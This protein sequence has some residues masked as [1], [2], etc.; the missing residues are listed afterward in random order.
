ML[1]SDYFVRY[2]EGVDSFIFSAGAD[3]WQALLRL[4]GSLVDTPLDALNDKLEDYLEAAFNLGEVSGLVA[5]LK[6]IYDLGLAKDYLERPK[7]LTR[8]QKSA[9]ELFWLVERLDRT[10][11]R[12][13]ESLAQKTARLSYSFYR[14]FEKALKAA[15]AGLPK[16]S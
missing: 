11:I 12:R 5:A 16:G 14:L 8:L 9:F 6:L 10:K 4:R 2:H 7:T 1:F 3:S 15:K 13:N